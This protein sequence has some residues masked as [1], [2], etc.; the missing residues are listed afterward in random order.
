MEL[1]SNNTGSP[2][3][4]TEYKGE[5]LPFSSVRI[6]GCLSMFYLATNYKKTAKQKDQ[7]EPTHFTD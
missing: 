1:G 5:R 7:V 3:C 6:I 2:P 4:R